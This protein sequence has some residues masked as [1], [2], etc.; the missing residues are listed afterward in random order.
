MQRYMYL[1]WNLGIFW[2]GPSVIPWPWCQVSRRN[3]CFWKSSTR[4]WPSWRPPPKPRPCSWMSS[5]CDPGWRTRNCRTGMNCGVCLKWR[6]P[7]RSMEISSFPRTILQ[8]WT[9]STR[10]WRNDIADIGGLGGGKHLV[11]R[12]FF[13]LFMALLP[14][15]QHGTP[16]TVYIRFA[17][18]WSDFV[19]PSKRLLFLLCRMHSTTRHRS[20]ERWEKRRWPKRNRSR[21]LRCRNETCTTGPFEGGMKIYYCPLMLS[22]HRLKDGIKSYI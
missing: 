16:V 7:Q 1:S 9:N 17:A 13:P 3:W 21:K 22:S 19:Q 11:G 10:G 2:A 5:S 18:L 8:F 14:R 12:L 15:I 20:C 6:A 4:T